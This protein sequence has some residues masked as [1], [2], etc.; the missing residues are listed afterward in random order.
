MQLLT[1]DHVRSL[2]VQAL[3]DLA[4]ELRRQAD[5]GIK[6]D[7]NM[8]LADRL[9]HRVARIEAGDDDFSAVPLSDFD[10]QANG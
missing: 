3:L 8:L 7:I 1:D 9:S 10:P 6:Y 2:K 4:E 5:A